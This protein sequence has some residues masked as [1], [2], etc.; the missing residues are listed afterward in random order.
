VT[1]GGALLHVFACEGKP[2][3]LCEPYTS[4]APACTMSIR[5][6]KIF[7]SVQ[8]ACPPTW[9]VSGF[10]GQLNE[11]HN[12]RF[13]RWATGRAPPLAHFV[14]AP[15]K[16]QNMKYGGFWRHDADTLAEWAAAAA[17]RLRGAWGDGE[18]EAAAR[19]PF[20]AG[21]AARLSRE[22]ES[23]RAQVGGLDKFQ[24][25]CATTSAA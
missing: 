18:D 10:A 16:A 6:T 2:G 12:G 20:E 14:G 5:V 11:K 13:G 25:K 19:D 4:A 8:A 17:E 3:L 23:V 21:V 7:W 9:M 1:R 22:G 24:R 15:D